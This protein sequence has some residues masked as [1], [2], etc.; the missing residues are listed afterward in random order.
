MLRHRSLLSLCLLALAATPARG[1]QDEAPARPNILLLF[2]DD[3]RTDTIAAWGNPA[4]QTPHLDRLAAEGTSFQRAYCLGS[5]GGAV[6]VPS[7]AMLHTGR[8]YFGLNAQSFNGHPTLGGQLGEAGYTTFATGKWHNGRETLKQSF[9]S[10]RNLHLGGM[11]DHHAIQVEDLSAGEFSEQRT[12]P[13]HSSE[14]FADAA[15]GFLED[16]GGDEPWFV[17][18]SFTAPHDPR[19]PPPRW[20]EHYYEHLP[21]LPANFLPQHPWDIGMMTVRDEVLA[22]WPREPAVVRQQLAEYYGLISHMDEQ[23][24]R[25]LAALEARGEL[26]ETLIVFAADH[27]LALGSH[28]LLGKQSVY[29]HSLRAPL[30]ARGPGVPAAQSTSALVYLLDIMPTLLVEAGASLPDGMLGQDL[31]PLWRGERGWIRS[32]QLL[33]MGNTQRA[34]TD[35]RWK[36]IR[37]PKIDRLRLYDLASDPHELFDLAQR[38]E[39]S[40]RVAALSNDL[41]AWQ[42]RLG[43]GLAWTADTLIPAEIDL[44]G[45]QRSPDRWQPEWIVEKYFT[46]EQEGE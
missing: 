34:V 22:G 3:Q 6:C 44:S 20:R 28:G 45:R 36:L 33:S 16:Y 7:R 13:E 10:G 19:D 4:I 38:P 43:D 21:P 29:E 5:N 31:G 8:P 35:G 12:G 30:I 15:V 14:L 32:S 41:R 25:I 11:A 40:Q 39:H 27:G 18:V 26:D 9:Q 42:T 24:G 17:Y 2:A 23:I 1:A 46:T 37:Y